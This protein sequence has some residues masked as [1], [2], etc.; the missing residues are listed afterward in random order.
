MTADRASAEV[1]T[2]FAE[3]A[4]GAFFSGGHRS[5]DTSTREIYPGSTATLICSF[6]RGS[7][8]RAEEILHSR[9]FADET[10]LGRCRPDDQT[11]WSTAWTRL[12]DGAN[13]DLHQTIVGVRGDSDTVWRLL[14]DQIE[15]VEVARSRV[16]GLDAT[17]TALVVGLH[18][19]QHGVGFMHPLN[20]LSLALEKFPEPIWDQATRLAEQLEAAEAWQPACVFSR[21]EFNLRLG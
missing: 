18:A 9:G 6:R 13:V 17:A 11:V 1:M 3:L 10:G 7:Q 5:R 16:D 21:P 12:S 15:S 8:T 14:S 19:A 20:D 4:S 2:A